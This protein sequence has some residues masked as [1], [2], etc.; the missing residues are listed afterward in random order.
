MHVLRAGS[1]IDVQLKVLEDA[2][3]A[4]IDPL[5]SDVHKWTSKHVAL[6]LESLS[7]KQV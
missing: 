1:V 2:K 3:R 6:W 7:L 4:T 5:P